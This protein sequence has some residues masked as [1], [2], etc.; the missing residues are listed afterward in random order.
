[1]K[2]DCI[3]NELENEPLHT[4]IG[5]GAFRTELGNLINKYSKENGSDTPDFI[6]ADYLFNCLTNFDETV[7]RREIWYGRNKTITTPPTQ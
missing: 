6:L 4:E 7:G 5:S 2:D 1:M 3:K